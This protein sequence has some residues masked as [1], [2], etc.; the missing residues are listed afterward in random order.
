MEE[1][2]K[3]KSS[4]P[5]AKLKKVTI[6][7]FRSMSYDHPLELCFGERTILLGPNGAGKSNIIGFF[8]MLSYMMSRSF[9]AYV[10]S[11]GG[12][13]ALSY[14]GSKKTP[15]I[16]GALEF[17]VLN[18][19]VP[20][21][22]A[23]QFQLQY[24]VPDRLIVSE[25]K[26][27][28]HQLNKNKPQEKTLDPEYKESALAM[29]DD[30]TC[31][32]IYRM[33]SGCKAYQFNDSSTTGPLRQ[34][35]PEQTVKYLQSEGNNL[36]SF[37]L[38][39][40]NQYPSSYRNIVDYVS[41]VV[42]HFTDF[43][44]EPQGGYLSLQWKDDSATD[45]VFNAHQLSD[46]SIRFIALATLLLQPKELLP[47][48]IIIDEPELGLH[49]Y[50]IMQLAEMIRHA[51]FHTQVIISTQSCDLADAFGLNEVAIVEKDGED[52]HTTARNLSSQEYAQ[53]LE[54]YSLSEL[55]KKNVLGGNPH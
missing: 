33:L 46:G 18:K 42:P 22:S 27:S 50:A 30:P 34:T 43:Y 8:K 10:E 9:A 54:E 16:Q 53:W 5:K 4:T 35:V 20:E 29:S 11:E 31:R 47:P 45:Y 51:S 21:E 2:R 15:L 38:L 28:Y 14:Y 52:L 37:L 12:A 23:Y 32:V 26:V 24:A 6:G 41:D 44:L 17:E 1:K 25:E 36:P 7:G 13:N 49:P 19:E 48:V 55:W 3:K 40:R 39:L